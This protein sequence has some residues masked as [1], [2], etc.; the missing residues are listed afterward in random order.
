MGMGMEGH[1]EVHTRT[2]YSSISRG[3]MSVLVPGPDWVVLRLCFPSR[4]WHWSSRKS[5]SGDPAILLL[6]AVGVG[7]LV[8]V[9]VGQWSECRSGM[10]RRLGVSVVVEVVGEIE[11]M[12][13]RMATTVDMT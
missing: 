12:W 11:D 4:R 9:L 8:L 1:T 3:S 13:L 10:R 2:I 5:R 6:F 7:V